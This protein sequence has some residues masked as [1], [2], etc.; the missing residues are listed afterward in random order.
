MVDLP[1][2]CV[3][4]KSN[5]FFLLLRWLCVRMA[6]WCR[7]NTNSSIRCWPWHC[8][9]RTMERSESALVRKFLL[10]KGRWLIPWERITKSSL[11]YRP[12]VALLILSSSYYDRGITDV[13]D[14]GKHWPYHSVVTV[15]LSNW[16]FVYS[17]VSLLIVYYCGEHKQHS[18]NMGKHIL[19]YVFWTKIF[20][21]SLWLVSQYCVGSKFWSVNAKA[22]STCTLRTG[23]TMP[24]NNSI[25]S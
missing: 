25:S 10:T 21:W 6:A 22:R 16:F 8:K 15:I 7:G 18:L 3:M 12:V 19:F 1:P 20:L 17:V 11:I 9:Q 13:F 14:L 2:C 5:P 4:L 23:I 24:L